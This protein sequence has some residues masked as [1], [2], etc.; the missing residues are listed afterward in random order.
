MSL[1]SKNSMTSAGVL[2]ILGMVALYAGRTSLI[3]LV[4]AA[5]LVWYGTRSALGHSRN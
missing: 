4:P 2:T 3:V 5:L 1:I